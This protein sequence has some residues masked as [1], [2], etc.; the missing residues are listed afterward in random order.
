M[1]AAQIT[2]PDLSFA[3]NLLSRYNKNYKKIHWSAVKRIFRYVKGTINY[4][5]EFNKEGN[6][7]LLGYSDS[8]WGNKLNDRYS[9]SGTCFKLQGGLIS[10]A[11][12]KQNT[13]A[14]STTEAE[15]MALSATVQEALWL[16]QLIK[17]LD[18]LGP[19]GPVQIFCDNIGAIQIAKNDIVSQR[20][21]HID[22]RYHF[23]KQHV[24]M[25]NVIIDY[26]ATESM[27]ADVLTKPLSKAKFQNC[28]KDFG[29]C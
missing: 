9:V 27:T 16:K 22:I 20:S 4:K 12:K 23:L 5:L 2:R 11:S 19:N 8:D 1:Y 28:V 14:L 17:E 25:K 6:S 26:L 10:W 13:I 3:V 24:N 21:K 7:A 29:L 15:Y 18:P